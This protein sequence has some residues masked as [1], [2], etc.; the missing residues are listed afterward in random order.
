[1]LIP[2][3]RSAR[4]RA[5]EVLYEAEIKS[6]T[7]GAVLDMLPLQPDPFAVTLVRGIESHQPKL[8]RIISDHLKKGWSLE[9][10][11]TIDRLVLRVGVEELKHHPDT[12]TAVIL[13]ESVRLAKGF[14]T[15]D[16]GRFVNGVLAAVAR[17]VRRDNKLVGDLD[18]DGNLQDDGISRDS[19]DESVP[20]LSEGEKPLG[21]AFEDEPPTSLDA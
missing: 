21:L 16:S 8:D 12:P 15:D 4:E 6:L 19:A 9:R 18:V 1:M 17:Q 2:A 11:P 10:L 20:E 7:V 3:R 13:D 14:S 5:L